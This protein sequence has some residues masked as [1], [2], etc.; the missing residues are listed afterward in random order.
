MIEVF[1]S[2]RRLT[3]TP[4]TIYDQELGQDSYN[5]AGDKQVEAEFSVDGETASVRLTETPEAGAT[6]VVVR[7]VGRIWQ[8]INENASLVFSGTDI[9]RFLTAKQVNLPK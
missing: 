6:I 8:K 3:K 2:G 7:K 9:A 1:V 4:Y 5:G